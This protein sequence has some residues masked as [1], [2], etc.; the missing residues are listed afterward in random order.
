MPRVIL[1]IQ[2][3]LSL[4]TSGTIRLIIGSILPILGKQRSTTP[5]TRTNRCHRNQKLSQFSRPEI[6][7]TVTKL[8]ALSRDL[9]RIADGVMPDGNL[10]RSSP[11]IQQW[12]IVPAPFR[13]LVGNV[14]EHPSLA[15]GEVVT[16]QLFLIEDGKTWARTFS[17]YYRLGDRARNV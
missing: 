13:V 7:K 16:S 5:D 15:D 2:Q 11:I 4:P 14:A 8:E 17:R 9:R 3:I 1:C 6:M 12:R 10:I